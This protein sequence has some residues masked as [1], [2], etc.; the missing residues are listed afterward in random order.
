MHTLE[1]KNIYVSAGSACASNKPALS[2]TLQSIGLAKE[3][4]DSTV[5]FSFSVHTTK[6]EIDY[7]L[8]TLRAVVPMLQKYTRK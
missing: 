4:L 7:A 1:D 2:S 6:E 8:D 5:R 3:L